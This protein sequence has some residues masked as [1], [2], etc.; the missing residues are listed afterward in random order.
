MIA[1]GMFPGREE[2]ANLDWDVLAVLDSVLPVVDPLLH[3]TIIPTRN[4]IT[5]MRE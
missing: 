5:L 2:N 4:I 3:H 1:I